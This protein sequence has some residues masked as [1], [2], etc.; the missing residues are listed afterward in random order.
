MEAA[1]PSPADLAFDRRWWTLAV[2][3]LSL[4]IV[5]VG[6]SSLNVAIPT[7]SRDLHASQSQLQWVVAVYSLVFA[8]L[9]FSTGALGDRFGR[10]GALQLGL[11]LFLVGA[12]LASESTGMGQLIACRAI[13]GVAGALIMP[14][15]LSIIINV[16]PAHERPKAI[17]I[18]ASVTGAAGAFGPVASGL[19]L[20]HFW[21]GSIFLINV[22]VIAVAL[23]AGKFL[24]PKSRDPEESQFDPLGAV[25]SIIGIVAL[26]Y[27]LIEA[28]DKG[29]MSIGTLAA[30]AIALVVL[31]LFVA[32]ELHTPEPMLDMHY[33]RIPAFSTGTGG[34]I[35]VFV[36]MYGVMFLITQYFQEVLGY[37]PL[38]AALRLMP[39]AAI[40]MVVAPLTPKLSARFG[41]H[42]AVAFG[43]LLIGTGLFLLIGLTTHTPYAYVVMCLVPLTTGIALSMSP[44]TA[45][46]MSAVPPRRAGAG[47]AMNDATRELGAA[48]GI[49]VLGSVAASRYASSV[50]PALRGLSKADQ[51][52]ARTSIAGALHVASTL[53]GEAGRAL[54]SSAS[55]AFI[56]GIHLAVVVG[57]ILAV[58]SAVI[59]YRNLPHTLVQSGAM[60]GT[61]EALEEVAAMGLGG[62]PP[63]F[64]DVER[65]EE[66]EL[67]NDRR[68]HRERDRERARD[69]DRERSA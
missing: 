51:S 54:A 6:N 69:R 25:L 50:A 47:S 42:R 56:N 65:D 5:F 44:M 55:H 48:L 49:A 19:L 1:P 38:S 18:W 16:F 28:P 61:T 12:A 68:A 29:W 11:L 27:G 2:L 43:M 66:R 58:I 23:I 59:V 33:F 20:G 39:I 35:L 15:T 9:L 21:Y 31:A 10:K 60:H 46:I 32:W 62:V 7:L 8:G 26:V 22:P 14:S 24:V 13:M 52:S 57:A 40:M 41:A 36:A 3:C 67:E 45:S 4:L 53:P 17:A 34:M 63:V 64:A 30:F 37:S